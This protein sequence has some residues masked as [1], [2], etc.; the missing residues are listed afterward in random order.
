M[1]SRGAI[2][3]APQGRAGRSPAAGGLPCADG[4]GGRAVR[5]RGGGEG[6]RRQDGPPPSARVRHRRGRRAPG[7]RAMPGKR[8]RRGAGK[9]SGS[10]RRCPGSW[11]TCR[12]RCLRSCA[13]PSCNGARRGS[14]STGRS[15]GQVLDKIDEE[16][17]EL[18]AELE[19][20][21]ERRS[22]ER[23][24]RRSAVRGGQSRAPSGGRRRDRAAPGQ[25]Q[26]RAPLSQRSR[27]RCAPA[28]AASRTPRSTR[29]RRCGR[30]RK[31]GSGCIAV[32]GRS[33]RERP[34][35]QSQAG[36]GAGAARPL[37]RPGDRRPR[38]ADPAF[39]HLRPRRRLCAHQSGA[40]LRPGRQ[41]GLP[42]GRGGAVRARRRRR[43]PGV[44]L[45]HGGD[46]GA[47][48]HAPARRG[49]RRAAPDLLR[50][51]C[52]AR[53]VLRAS[54]DRAPPF[55][56]RRSGQ[57]RARGARRRSRRSSG[58]RRPPTRC[59]TW[60]TSPAPPRSRTPPARCSRSTAPPR[61]RS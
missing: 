10:C 6:D 13:R 23:R 3:R 33:A 29:W 30:R 36:N 53:Q 59:W 19:T 16:I 50:H 44:P 12:L 39:D 28:G 9:Q 1:R 40:H 54:R 34:V 37:R 18:R 26:V 49:D 22:A 38:A 42:S 25:R 27:T 56:G 51:A 58:S 15:D 35:T 20:G 7:R 48:P 55:R 47:V 61:R 21:R 4:Q 5:F 43:R 52:L 32:A 46:R 31:R 14:A 60:S 2:W 8:S 17:A 24:D 11:T 41:S 57:P 45:G